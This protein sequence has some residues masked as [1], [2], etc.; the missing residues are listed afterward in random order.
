MNAVYT[1]KGGE[2][3]CIAKSLTCLVVRVTIDT[4]IPLNCCSAWAKL[5]TK[6]GLNHPST[7]PTTP[8]HHTGHKLFGIQSFISNGVRPTLIP[9]LVSYFQERKVVVKWHGTV[10]SICDL[11]GRG[12]QGCTFGLIEYKSNS[13]ENANC[14]PPDMRYKFVDDQSKVSTQ[15]QLKVSAISE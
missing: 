10:S 8:T 14:V 2:T 9:L 11:P 6:I 1:F 7:T 4:V 13:N 15:C 3:A 12:P 5:N